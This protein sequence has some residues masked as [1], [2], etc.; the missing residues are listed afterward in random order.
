MDVTRNLKQR[1]VA[2]NQDGNKIGKDLQSFGDKEIW[3]VD[4]ELTAHGLWT[5]LE[6]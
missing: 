2:C 5:K 4:F 6:E 1:F 3:R